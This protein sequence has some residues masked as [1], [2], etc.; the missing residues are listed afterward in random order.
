MSTTKPVSM[1][2]SQA[3]T[4][5]VGPLHAH[6]EEL[7]NN[8]T[9][10][11]LISRLKKKRSCLS[12]HTITAISEALASAGLPEITEEEICDTL[13]E[14]LGVCKSSQHPTLNSPAQQRSAELSLQKPGA[15]GTR[16]ESLRGSPDSRELQ[17]KTT[18]RRRRSPENDD[19]ARKKLPGRSL[20]TSIDCNTKMTSVHAASPRCLHQQAAGLRVPDP[21]VELDELTPK[22]L[23]IWRPGQRRSSA[24]N[25]APAVVP[26]RSSEGSATS[27][28]SGEP[29]DSPLRAADST[30]SAQHKEVPLFV[31]GGPQGT[32]A[33]DSDSI[34]IDHVLDDQACTSTDEEHQKEADAS[35]SL[36]SPHHKKRLCGDSIDID[37]VLDDQACTSTDEHQKEADASPSL[38]RPHHKKRLCDTSGVFFDE[39]ASAGQPAKEPVPQ[40]IVSPGTMRQDVLPQPSPPLQSSSSSGQVITSRVVSQGTSEITRMCM[41]PSRP[42]AS[43]VKRPRVRFTALEEEAIVY[44]VMKYGHGSWKEIRDD[45]FFNGRRPTELSDKYRNLEKYNHLPRVKQRVKAKLAAR[46]NPLKELRAILRQRQRQTVLS[47][48]DVVPSDDDG[49]AAPTEAAREKPDKPLEATNRPPRPESASTLVLSDDD[50]V[51]SCSKELAKGASSSRAAV[52]SLSAELPGS[53]EIWTSSSETDT[54][55]K[56]PVHVER[57]EKQ[58]R[59]PF[60]PLETEALVSGIIKYGKGSWAHI[61]AEG[62]FIGRTSIQ[63]SDKFRNLR[64]YRYLPAI[65]ETVKVKIAR[66]EDPLQELRKVSSSHWKR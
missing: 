35:P 57:K 30:G 45:G 8:L 43:S 49:I 42:A 54:S 66:G 39:N 40:A 29:C 41:K 32:T 11:Q 24:C 2:K 65:M 12:G 50:D 60:T 21:V 53:D 55:G 33:S 17:F 38:L 16:Q 63:L 52:P 64:Q 6:E 44:G 61:L 46:V 28:P 22:E 56:V 36:L 27:Q 20:R 59:V 9:T 51:A 14:A 19:K 13:G 4:T 3:G 15:R 37:H 31:P 48:E 1:G 5:G 26:H 10:D 34:D 58:K 18:R 7:C 47:E 23:S 25:R 62:G